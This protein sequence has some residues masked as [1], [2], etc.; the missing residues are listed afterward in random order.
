MKKTK[1]YQCYTFSCL[2]VL[3]LITNIAVAQEIEYDKNS[4]YLT[5]GTVINSSQYAISYERLL[6]QKR[7]FRTGIKLNYG[8]MNSEDLEFDTNAK[9]Y[10]N[11]KGISGILLFNILDFSMGLA[12]T[13]YNLAP[14]IS[15]DPEVDYN[16]KLSGINFV[17]SAGLRFTS[18][19]FMLKVGI[20]NLEYLYLGAGFNF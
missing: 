12:F 16:E 14:G 1:F 20:G 15:P 13:E 7:H 19:E 18:D 9:V 17:G 6:Y 8:I 11:Y 4:I 2:F 5:Y 3:S 10:N